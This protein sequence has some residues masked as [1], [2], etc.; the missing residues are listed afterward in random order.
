MDSKIISAII[1]ALGMVISV[2]LYTQDTA[3]NRCVEAL[4]GIENPNITKKEKED[5]DLHDCQSEQQYYLK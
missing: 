3:Y 2:Y 4:S 1:I 5:V